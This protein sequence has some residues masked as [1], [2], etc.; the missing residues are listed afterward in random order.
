MSVTLSVCFTFDYNFRPIFWIGQ[1]FG[2]CSLS[3]LITKQLLECHGVWRDGVRCVC[4]GGG[5][6]M[7]SSSICRCM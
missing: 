3:V 4:D 1:H 5:S 2:R 7:S 6:W